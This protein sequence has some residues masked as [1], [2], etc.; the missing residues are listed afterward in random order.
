MAT[1][2]AAAGGIARRLVSFYNQHRW[3]TF[4]LSSG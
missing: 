4:I 2:G 1:D 3:L